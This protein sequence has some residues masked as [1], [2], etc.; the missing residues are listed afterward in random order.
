MTG[1]DG[2][3]LEESKQTRDSVPRDR[4]Q[5]TAQGPT[6]PRRLRELRLTGLRVWEG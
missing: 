5:V 1:K 6:E 3:S 2:R 4:V